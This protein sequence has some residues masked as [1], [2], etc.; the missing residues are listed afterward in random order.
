MEQRWFGKP[1]GDEN[2]SASSNLAFEPLRQSA[3]E[4]QNVVVLERLLSMHIAM[5][6]D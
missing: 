3:A 4:V 2:D 6:L 1:V 5:E